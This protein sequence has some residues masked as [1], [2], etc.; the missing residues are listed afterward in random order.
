VFASSFCA[1][2]RLKTQDFF[3]QH[4]FFLFR[5]TPSQLNDIVIVSIDEA[6]RRK[7]DNTRWPWNRDVIAKLIRNIAN[8]S[9]KIIGLDIVF[10]GKT[11]LEH[12]KQL[13][14]ALKSHPNILA[15]Y[16]LPA[17]PGD[18]LFL[19]QFSNVLSGI[20]H[21]TKP[22]GPDNIVRDLRTFYIDKNNRYTSLEIEILTSYLNI[23]PEEINWDLN[24]SIDMGRKLSIPATPDGFTEINYL[25]HAN[26]IP[27]I[28]AYLIVENIFNPKIFKDKMVLV[29]ATDPLIH[30]MHLTPLGNFPGVSIV[31]NSLIMFLNNRFI[32]NITT[33]QILLPLLI[34]AFVSILINAKMRFFPASLICGS[35]TLIMFFVLLYLRAQ[36]IQ[37]DYFGILFLI[38]SAYAIPNIYKY[39]Y[40]IYMSNKLKNLAIIDPITGFHTFRYFL[41]RLDKELKNKAKNLDFLV[42][43]LSNYK[44]LS[45]ALNFD[46]VKS[47]IK[48]TTG[49]IKVNLQAQF[50]NIEFCRV[51]QNKLGV[52]VLKQDSIST[53]NYLKDFL[54]TLAKVDFKIEDKIVKISPKGIL[55]HTPTNKKSLST[56]LIYNMETSLKDLRENPDK[57]FISL[58]LKEKIMELKQE[59][60][61][62]DILDFLASDFE[63][64]NK[65]L[66]KA[67]R[68]LQT[69]QK[70]TET[71]YFET[72]LSLIK[73]LEEKDMYTQGHSE[74]VANYSLAIAKE[75]KLSPQE[76]NDIHKAALLHDIGKIG[77]PEHTLH[78]KEK[79][80]EEEFNLIKRHAIISVEILKP[81]KAFK[82]L[83]PIILH[84]HERFDGTG[85][86]YGLSE[87]MIPRGAQILAVADSFDAITCGRGYKKGT[88]VKAALKELD[89]NKGSQFNPLYVIAFK[90]IITAGLIK[91]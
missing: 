27:S 36:D 45:L 63:E 81:I 34:L 31:A 85:Y 65:E 35:V 21:V 71:A 33:W 24:G 62:E 4:S 25:A 82:D 49:Y 70:E 42:I 75:L 80:T 56:E 78:K 40:L 59:F 91:F 39:S 41:L 37:F 2:L 47:L 5:E 53:E 10:S 29:G 67:L 66:E 55:I 84:H 3:T 83:L 61:K 88:T 14:E 50:H 38:I 90:R 19:P 15:G 17:F 28:P 54:N 64:R 76:C 69:S 58:D 11:T 73:A 12:D 86:P 1:P 7:L 18:E 52:I 8:A 9:P 74:R 43:T 32:Y 60:I 16:T 68:K 13:E 26:E 77:I 48:L 20:G 30:D 22:V 72:M 79:L 23:S 57:N 6:S 51:S 46:E 44:Q 89:K 87:S